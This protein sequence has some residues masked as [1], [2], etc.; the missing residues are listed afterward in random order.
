MDGYWQE[1]R[2]LDGLWE[3][4]EEKGWDLGQ[5]RRVELPPVFAESGAYR[6]SFHHRDHEAGESLFEVR[7]TQEGEEIR[8]LLVWGVPTPEEARELLECYGLGPDDEPRPEARGSWISILPPVV[9][10]S[11]S[12]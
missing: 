11:E 4:F 7:E 10:A 8:A 3:R 6:I 2:Y 1:W 12:L 9:H 5:V